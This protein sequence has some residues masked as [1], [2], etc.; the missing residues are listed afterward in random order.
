MSV[1][2]ALK[3]Q[4][5]GILLEHRIGGSMIIDDFIQQFPDA[6]PDET[7]EWLESL[8]AAVGQGGAVRG[9]YLVSRLIKRAREIGVDVPALVSTSYIN[10]IPPEEEPWFPGDEQMERRIRRAIR[11]NAAVMVI[12][13]S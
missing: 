1:R 8:D 5:T 12:T 7:R 2:D 6:D 4:G 10:S 11:W 13:A 3:P 9:Q